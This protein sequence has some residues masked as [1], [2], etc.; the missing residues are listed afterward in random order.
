MTTNGPAIDAERGAPLRDRY[1]TRARSIGYRLCG[2]G[3]SAS[4]STSSTFRE[5]DG[6]PDGM[7]VDAEGHVWIC[8]FRGA[9]ITRFDPAGRPVLLVPMPTSQVTKLAFGGPDLTHDLCDDRGARP[10]P[11]DRSDGGPCVHFRRGRS[12]ADRLDLPSSRRSARRRKFEFSG[13]DL[14][15]SS[16]RNLSRNHAVTFFEPFGA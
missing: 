2:R 9:R 4:R 10:R 5:G 1:V 15:K 16:P 13:G 12:P 6:H 3:S 14:W 7:A 11:R 8:H